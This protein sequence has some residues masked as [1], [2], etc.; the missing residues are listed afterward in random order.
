MKFR[1]LVIIA[2]FAVVT[3][4]YAQDAPADSPRDAAPRLTSPLIG[5]WVLDVTLTYG[6]PFQALQ[7]F[8]AAGTMS[9]TSNLLAT[10][11]E[12]PGHGAWE[13][14]G[15]TYNATFELFFFN[16]DHTPAGIVRVRET[17]TLKDAN[18]LTGFAVADLIFA[19]GT[20]LENVDAGPVTGRRVRVA[21]VRPEEQNAFPKNGAFARGAW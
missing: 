21:P 5:S 13:R 11:T 1:N 9:E 12:G 20:V 7:T 19:D 17:M 16:E 6:T 18:T 15:D 14:D 8:H 4:V 3:P 2:V 10:L